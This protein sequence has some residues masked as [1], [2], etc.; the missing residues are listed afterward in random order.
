MSVGD[1]H[2]RKWQPDRRAFLDPEV[3]AY[4]TLLWLYGY[5]GAETRLNSYEHAD[6]VRSWHNLGRKNAGGRGDIGHTGN[7]S[8]LGRSPAGHKSERK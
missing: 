6:D 3:Q 5:E 1:L 8:S 7:H 2:I 4:Q